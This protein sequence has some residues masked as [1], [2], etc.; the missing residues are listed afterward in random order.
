MVLPSSSDLH[1]AQC[2]DSGLGW[3]GL[4]WAI[5]LGFEAGEGEGREGKGAG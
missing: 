1:T 2:V 4:G 5:I 3:T